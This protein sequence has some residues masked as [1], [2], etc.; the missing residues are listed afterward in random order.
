MKK[1]S[2]A[3]RLAVLTLVMTMITASLVSGTYSKYVLTATASDTARV[4]KFAF[5]MKDQNGNTMNQT[6][7]SNTFDI[8]KY[9][10]SGVLNNGTYAVNGSTKL[11]APGTKGS[12]ALEID[13]LSEVKV[14]PSIV[15]T[16]TNSG[17]PIYYSLNSDGSGTRYISGN[18]NPLYGKTY[19]SGTAYSDLTALSSALGL[20][21]MNATSGAAVVTNK[22]IYWFWN[23]DSTTTGT[24]TTGYTDATDTALGVTGTATVNLSMAITMTQSDT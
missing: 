18:T 14:Q 12:L 13:N 20:S 6:T 17:L 8:F 15:F 19:N 22:T 10:D 21:T 3:L 16:E 9:M 7:L 11:L 24:Y 1:K 2:I 23:Y 4:A 5:S